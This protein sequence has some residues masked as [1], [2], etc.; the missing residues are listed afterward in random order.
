MNDAPKTPAVTNVD[1]QSLPT[2]ISTSA[3]TEQPSEELDNDDLDKVSGGH[4]MT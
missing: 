3:I 2:A 4:K 1:V